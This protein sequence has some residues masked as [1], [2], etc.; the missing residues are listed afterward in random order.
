MTLTKDQKSEIFRDL[1]KVSSYQAGIRAGLD[2]TYK[3]RSS[4]ISAVRR[5]TGE[6]RENPS[7]YGISTE[8]L[9]MVDKSFDE[10]KKNSVQVIGKELAEAPRETLE[11]KDVKF[12]VETGKIWS[13]H[14]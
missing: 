7:K 1:V 5:V 13:R 9:D 10:R 8:I 2:R 14:T 12:L 11:D 6:V 4:I 3:K